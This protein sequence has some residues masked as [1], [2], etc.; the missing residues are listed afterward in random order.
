MG[1]LDQGRQGQTGNE[2]LVVVHAQDGIAEEILVPAKLDLS[3]SFRFAG[4][5]MA[6]A[7]KG[8]VELEGSCDD[9]NVLEETF[10]RFCPVLA[11]VLSSV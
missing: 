11:H 3:D 1:N 7:D 8:K 2:A 6:P 5:D 10:Q 4:L 9:V